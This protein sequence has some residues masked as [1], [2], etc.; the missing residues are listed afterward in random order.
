MT[1]VHTFL[2]TWATLAG[3]EPLIPK[4][5]KAMPLY[6]LSYTGTTQTYRLSLPPL[7]STHSIKYDINN[8][9]PP[10]PCVD[11]VL[12]FLKKSCY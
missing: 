1:E 12:L 3:I 7:Y 4:E 6:R 9:K 5:C 11:C 10:V 8:N 2:L